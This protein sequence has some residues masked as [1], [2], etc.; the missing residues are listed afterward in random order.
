MRKTLHLNSWH[1]SDT[2]FFIFKTLVFLLVLYGKV[3]PLEHYNFLPTFFDMLWIAAW[4]VLP[5]LFWQPNNRIP[6]ISILL[7]LALSG[8]LYIYFSHLS[9]DANILL[10]FPAMICGF[11]SNK[12]TA[13]WVIPVLILLS[14]IGPPEESTIYVLLY[15]S[16]GFTFGRL[17]ESY[18]L[19]AQLV[20]TVEEKNAELVQYSKQMQSIAL[21]EE[22]N[23]LAQELHDTLGHTF[24]SVLVGLDVAI[25]QLE[26]NPIDTKDRLI[27]LRSVA[28]ESLDKIR[29]QIHNIAPTELDLSLRE[30]IPYLC[31]EFSHNTETKVDYEVIGNI[32][33]PSIPI[34][35]SIIR[36]LQELLTNS[37]K[38]GKATS[39]NVILSLSHPAITLTVEDNGIGI[40][41]LKFGFGLNGIKERME[42]LQGEISIIALPG[43]GVKVVCLIPVR[44]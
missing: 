22:R 30:Y 5:F 18:I 27:N 17:R 33:D 7:E 23:R 40:T 13:L 28:S 42:T 4:Y 1:S 16:F 35:L 37:K 29:E 10:L 24:I 34:K 11:L 39:I 32:E 31:E 26:L 12:K 38:H 21:L 2:A 41:E 3:G 36:C 6:S 14:R 43:R 8:S 19:Q 20:R 15:F 25:R 9:L 44:E